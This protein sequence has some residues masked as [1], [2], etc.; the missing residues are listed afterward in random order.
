MCAAI[1]QTRYATN[2]FA[3][4][5]HVQTWDPLAIGFGSEHPVMYLTSRWLFIGVQCVGVHS[6]LIA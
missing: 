3:S 4:A 6:N 1:S 5:V 2:A